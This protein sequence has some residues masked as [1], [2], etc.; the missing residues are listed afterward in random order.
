VVP[1]VD[2]ESELGEGFW[3]LGTVEMLQ[4]LDPWVA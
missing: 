1:V 3:D 2:G 4:R